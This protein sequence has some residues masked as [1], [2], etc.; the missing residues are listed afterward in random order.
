MPSTKQL[1]L[2]LTS[3]ATSRETARELRMLKEAWGLPNIDAVIRQMLDAHRPDMIKA[4]GIQVIL[5]DS[6]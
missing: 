6:L 4:L 5:G 3:I 2:T 1:R